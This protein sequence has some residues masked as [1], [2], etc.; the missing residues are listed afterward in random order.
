M[1]K[2]IAVARRRPEVLPDEAEVGAQPDHRLHSHRRLAG[3]HRGEQLDVL[4]RRARREHVGQGGPLRQPVRRLQHPPALPAGRARASWWAPRWSRQ[5]IIRHGAKMLYAVASATVPKFTVVVRKGYGAGY[6]V[7]NGRAYEPD[8]LVAWPGAE[9]GVMG[10]EGMVSIAA[11][12]LLQSAETPEAAD[13]LKTELA[14]Q[15][16]AAHQHLPHRRAR[17]GRRR[18]RPPRH[19]AAARARAQA[20]ARTRRSSGPT[21]GERSR[22]SSPGGGRR[23]RQNLSDIQQLLEDQRGGGWVPAIV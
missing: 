13:A 4:R 21:A 1:H 9:I 14:A 7:M 23:F 5:G 12:K 2:V 18:D 15:L 20:H 11:R 3:G 19:P 17:H 10:P 16:R 22:P 8:L 6:Y